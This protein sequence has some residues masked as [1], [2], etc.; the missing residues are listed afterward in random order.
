[1]SD[2]AEAV[3]IFVIGSGVLAYGHATG[4]VTIGGLTVE[5]SES[6]SLYWLI[7]LIAAGIAAIGILLF[8]TD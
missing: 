3:I 6:A 8:F 7:M 1:M 5:K 4:D 2:S